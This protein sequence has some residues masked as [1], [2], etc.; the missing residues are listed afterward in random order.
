MLPAIPPATGNDQQPLYSIRLVRNHLQESHSAELASLTDAELESNSLY[1]CRECDD[2][3]YV[4][5]TALNNHV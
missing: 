4:S 2:K 5:L 3:L 1:V